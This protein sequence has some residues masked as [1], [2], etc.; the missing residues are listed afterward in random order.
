MTII[1]FAL[2]KA[3]AMMKPTIGQPRA[4]PP[5]EPE[6]KNPPPA[7][8]LPSKKPEA[9]K[10]NGPA[11]LPLHLESESDSDFAETD[12]SATPTSQSSGFSAGGVPRPTRTGAAKLMPAKSR[13]E[14]STP[15][16]SP[17]SDSSQATQ[18]LAESDIDHLPDS[19]SE[20]E[21]LAAPL[22]ARASPK[23]AERHAVKKV[24]K[25]KSP[26]KSPRRKRGK[27]H[28][29]EDSE[30]TSSEEDRP[31][32]KKKSTRAAAKHKARKPRHAWHE[33][34]SDEETSPDEEEGE[35]GTEDDDEDESAES[36]PLPQ[37]DMLPQSS[38]SPVIDDMMLTDSDSSEEE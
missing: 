20:D 6:L 10:A 4:S 3:L 33:E 16:S 8:P 1:L 32:K 11:L 7:S 22:K 26:K 24:R 27:S 35:D 21:P 23:H 37:R 13:S 31:K 30:S 34:E 2:L 14:P 29:A 38:R 12:L 15:S 9:Q 28:A 25:P 17:S 19:S 18:L 36:E 5:A